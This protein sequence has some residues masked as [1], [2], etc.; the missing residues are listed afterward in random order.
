MSTPS[1]GRIDVEG[2]EG[3][4]VRTGLIE[5]TL[6]PELGGKIT[7]LCDT[8]NGREWLWRHPRFKY[9]RVPHGSSY[10]KEADTGGWDECFP[11]VAECRYPSAPWQ[12]AAVQDHGEL[13]SQI[14]GFEIVEGADSV[15]LQN[16]WQGVVLP[17]TFSRALTLTSDSSTIRVDYQARN[18]ADQ[19]INFVWCIHPL[20]AIEPEM[21]LILPPAARFH[22]GGSYPQDLVSPEEIL[23][24]PFAAPGLDLPV[25][26]QTSAGRAIKIWSEPLSLGEGWA[27]LRADDG[28]LTMRWDTALLPQ[29]AVW[30]NFGAWAADGGTPYYNLG[31]EPCIGAQD[32]LADAVTQY[33]LFATLPPHESKTWWLEIELTT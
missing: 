20:L 4:K 5:L 18:S 28:E 25:L 22:V 21:E 27:S 23:T 6:V 17:Y 10:V 2:F 15:A 9:K 1:V 11:S 12:G 19:Q 24:Y 26:P 8:R 29:L 3:Y 7:S 30:M 33:D 13:W 31:L 14:A 32:S 16:R